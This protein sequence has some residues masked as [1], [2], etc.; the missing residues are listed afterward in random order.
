MTDPDNKKDLRRQKIAEK[1]FKNDHL[2]DE[3]RFVSKSKKQ[4]KRKIQDIRAEELWEDWE[5]EV[6]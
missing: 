2:S 6:H 1:N 3:D 4:H 5:D